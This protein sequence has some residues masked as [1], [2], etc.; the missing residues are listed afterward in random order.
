M[1][2]PKMNHGVLRKQL[3]WV[4]NNMSEV[5]RREGC[6]YNFGHGNVCIRLLFSYMHFSKVWNVEITLITIIPFKMD[7]DSQ[8]HTVS[9]KL[10]FISTPRTSLSKKIEIIPNRT[11]ILIHTLYHFFYLTCISRK[12]IRYMFV[13]CTYTDKVKKVW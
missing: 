12:N 2:R 3:C 8:A 5:L 13:M 10:C 9:L 7:V 6:W 4:N 11:Y 1:P